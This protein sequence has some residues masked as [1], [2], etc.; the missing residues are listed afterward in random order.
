MSKELE[1]TAPNIS[2]K[3]LTIIGITTTINSF[4]LA[5]HI[6]NEL[7]TN[8]TLYKDFESYDKDKDMTNNFKNYYLKGQSL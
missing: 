7:L 4:S 6:N 2:S 5:Q 1:L 3:D 8:L